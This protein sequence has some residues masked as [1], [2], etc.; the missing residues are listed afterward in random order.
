M[1]FIMSYE[2]LVI[3]VMDK[4]VRLANSQL[5]RKMWYKLRCVC[6]DYRKRR[7]SRNAAQKTVVKNILKDLGFRVVKKEWSR[8]VYCYYFLIDLDDLTS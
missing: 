7:P 8:G 6:P 4:I 2:E 3:Q 1:V 5:S